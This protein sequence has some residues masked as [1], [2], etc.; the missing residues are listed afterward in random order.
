MTPTAA[1][2]QFIAVLCAGRRCPA[3]GKATGLGSRK[4]CQD[5]YC[6][7]RRRQARRDEQKAT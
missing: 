1:R 6:A 3:C 5:V 4:Y 2:D 7:A